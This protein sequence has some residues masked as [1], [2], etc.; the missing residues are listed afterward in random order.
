MKLAQDSPVL[1]TKEVV[2]FL[3]AAVT[4]GGGGLGGRQGETTL[5]T[6]MKD[7]EGSRMI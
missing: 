2:K 3:E 5:C 4:S 6:I 1:S 7:N